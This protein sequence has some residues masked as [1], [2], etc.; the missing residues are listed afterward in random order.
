MLVPISLRYVL[1]HLAV[2]TI[3]PRMRFVR[4]HLRACAVADGKASPKSILDNQPAAAVAPIV[5][6]AV[7]LLVRERSFRQFLLNGWVCTVVYYRTGDVYVESVHVT[8][9]RLPRA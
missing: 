3:I 6:L 1:S 4:N 8:L 9:L 7:S 5:T 2:C